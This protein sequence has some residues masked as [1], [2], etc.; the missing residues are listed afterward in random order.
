MSAADKPFFV[1]FL[2][3][4]RGL[5]VFLVGFAVGLAIT[6]AASGWVAGATQ[7]DPGPGAFRGGAQV[8]G[9]LFENP[10]PMVQVVDATKAIAAG[11]MVLLSGIGKRG[12]QGRAEGLAGQYVQVSGARLERGTIDMIQ[13]R[14]GKRGLRAA[15][16]EAPAPVT[17]EPLG[18]WRLAGEICD[19]KC[20]AGAMRPGSG[21]AHKACANLCLIG[22]VPPVFVSS[23]PVE[24]SE[25][26]VIGAP[27]GGPVSDRLLDHTA[28]YVSVEGE[29]VRRGKLL[30]FLIDPTTVTPL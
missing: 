12:V 15:M 11:E 1:G 28:V 6:F 17:D 18:R 27:D 29:I 20:Y 14:G 2:P 13:V 23:R 3:V 26:L 9:V 19:G 21:L 24:G 7:P 22:G 4:P 16:G 8:K 25:F 5:R 10:Y 30:L